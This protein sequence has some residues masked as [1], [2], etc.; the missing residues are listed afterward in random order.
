MG[1]ALL[2]ALGGG[3][4]RDSAPDDVQG[5]SG[6]DPHAAS[7]LLQLVYDELRRWQLRLIV[8]DT[9]DRGQREWTARGL[10]ISPDPPLRA[11]VFPCQI[12]GIAVARLSRNSAT[13]YIGS[14]SARP[15]WRIWDP[16]ACVDRA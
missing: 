1:I 7:R 14:R 8:S 2:P 3:I 5:G 4:P 15:L 10:A 16:A 11:A 13:D 9:L 12:V 6:D